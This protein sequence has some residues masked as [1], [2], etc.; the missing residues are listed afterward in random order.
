[1]HRCR[2][3]QHLAMAWMARFPT[4]FPGCRGAGTLARLLVRIVRGRRPVR[5]GRILVE[6]GFQTCDVL[7]EL[8]QLIAYSAQI[9]LHGRRGLCPV[10][11]GKGKW[12]DGVSRLR[13]RFHDISRRQT[14]ESDEW[15]CYSGDGRPALEEK[16]R[17]RETPSAMTCVCHGVLPC[18][19]L[20][21]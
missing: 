15:T 20:R 13:P 10:L 6:T 18:D 3:Q 1:M 14:P 9:G 7:L 4:R 17:E 8:T 21:C 5:R 11:R 2:G 12:P 19:R 16:T